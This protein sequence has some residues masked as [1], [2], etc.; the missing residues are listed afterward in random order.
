M[1]KTNA[2]RQAEYRARHLARQGGAGERLNMVVSSDVKRAL[3]RLASCYGVTQRA[4]LER[5]IAEAEQ[6]APA[7]YGLQSEQQQRESKQ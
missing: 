5:L 3:E 4:M 7:A 6:A 2:Q 1:G